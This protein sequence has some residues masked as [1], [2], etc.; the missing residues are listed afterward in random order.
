VLQHRNGRSFPQ[1]SNTPKLGLKLSA[2]SKDTNQSTLSLRANKVRVGGKGS[3]RRKQKKRK[4]KPTLKKESIN[5]STNTSECVQGK[6]ITTARESITDLLDIPMFPDEK[7]LPSLTETD[8]ERLVFLNLPVDE[9]LSEDT[10]VC[11][12]THIM[13]VTDISVFDQASTASK[14][15]IIMNED[16]RSQYDVSTSGEDYVANAVSSYKRNQPKKSIKV[17]VYST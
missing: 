14:I 3:V 7:Y 15:Q 4:K 17:L 8:L 9:T 11:L 6:K 2:D 16:L 1:V 13:P 5:G 12:T 10:N